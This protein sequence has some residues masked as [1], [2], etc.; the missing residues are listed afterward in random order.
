MGLNC[1]KII[2]IGTGGGYGESVI[3]QLGTDNWIVIDSC[4]NP[5]TKK[6][7]PLEYFEDNNIDLDKVKLII[8]S[9]WHDDHIKGLDQ[10]LYNCRN[11]IFAF[12]ATTE[13]KKF[14]Q[15]LSLD[16]IVCEGTDKPSATKMLNNCLK[17]ARD[18]KSKVKDI[19]QDKTLFSVCG[20]RLNA[21]IFSLSP[22]ETVFKEFA[23]AIGQMIESV[24][25]NSF[26]RP[27]ITPNDQSV[28]VLVSVN[29]HSALL[30]ADLE[31]S[32]DSQKGWVCIL[33]ECECIKNHTPSVF[34]IP[35]HGSVTAYEPRVW[36]ELLIN[37]PICQ[38][39]PFSKGS[40]YL[41]EKSML[42]EMLD[43]TDDLYLTSYSKP[44][45]PKKRDKK[46][47]RNIG[48]CWSIFQRWF[49]S[50]SIYAKS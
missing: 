33:D 40:K 18:R 20:T 39:T 7:L 42:L 21:S 2:L 24:G 30:G 47:E 3:V 16:N 10:V 17:I 34:K 8:A 9:H 35:H 15:F 12:T 22:S 27:K 45:K 28:V 1:F 43:K 6:S 41:P 31:T 36:N 29:G 11:A 37:K 26:R 46:I 23:T 5:Y 48:T 50:Y 44:K 4:T 14:T 19:T 38:I 13:F 32:V 49:P 25:D